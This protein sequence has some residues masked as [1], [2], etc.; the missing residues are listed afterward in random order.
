MERPVSKTYIEWTK[1]LITCHNPEYKDQLLQMIELYE[2]VRCGDVEE[3]NIVDLLRHLKATYPD[4]E[5]TI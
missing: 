3:Y 1:Q 5:F 4:F 2:N